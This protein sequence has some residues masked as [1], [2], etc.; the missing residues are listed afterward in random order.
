VIAPAPTF[1][2][3]GIAA[4]TAT[5][6]SVAGHIA[7]GAP[8]PSAGSLAVVSGLA[9]TLALG[10]ARRE[11]TYGRLLI[12]LGCAQVTAHAV[13]SAWTTEAVPHSG[14]MALAHAA[15]AVAIAGLL[16]DADRV[17]NGLAALLRESAATWRPLVAAPAPVPAAATVVPANPAPRAI[18]RISPV[19]VAPRRGPPA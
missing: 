19:L 2:R 11:W 9:V 18:R 12:V 4:T 17:V 13:F 3:A 10:F 6:L 8:R 7:G 5:V 1:S 14:G 16:A 15:A